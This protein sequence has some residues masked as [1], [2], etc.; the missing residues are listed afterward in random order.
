MSH[1]SDQTVELDG[2]EVKD[3]D[4][5]WFCDITA[6]VEVES[7]TDYGDN[8]R[9]SWGSGPWM[10]SKVVECEAECVRVDA[11]GKELETKTLEGQAAIDFVGEDELIQRAEEAHH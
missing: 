2:H 9:T 1:R 11:D 3:G 6:E 5:V 10:E 7:G 8:G 4:E